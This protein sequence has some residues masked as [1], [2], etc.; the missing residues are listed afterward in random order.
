MLITNKGDNDF[1]FVTNGQLCDS[2]LSELTT[3]AERLLAA[4]S[5]SPK[6]K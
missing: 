2:T 1:V 6:M 5:V 3:V 4:E